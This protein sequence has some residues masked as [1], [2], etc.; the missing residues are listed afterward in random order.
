MF[1]RYMWLLDF[2]SSSRLFLHQ[3][4]G[5]AT[6][7]CFSVCS[8][9][10]MTSAMVYFAMTYSK[11]ITPLLTKFILCQCLSSRFMQILLVIRHIQVALVV[12]LNRDGKD[13][14]H[15]FGK[16]QMF[17]SSLHVSDTT[18]YSASVHKPSTPGC[19]RLNHEIR[20]SVRSTSF[21]EKDF[22]STDPVVQ[23]ENMQQVCH[24]TL[25]D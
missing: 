11:S 16:R 25:V 20:S 23:S 9:L 14:S 6:R 19:L 24:A 17:I 5:K 13:E 12:H 2:P 22:R 21:I 3:Y 18:M 10:I 7:C 8:V 1:A 4:V 15:E